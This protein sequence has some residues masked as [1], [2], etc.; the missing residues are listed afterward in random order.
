MA[1]TRSGVYLMCLASALYYSFFLLFCS[2]ESTLKSHFFSL[3]KNIR[4]NKY[5]VFK[6]L[7]IIKIRAFVANILFRVDSSYRKAVFVL[8]WNCFELI[9]FWRYSQMIS[10]LAE[11]C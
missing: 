11:N 5:H 10:F 3:K 8:L 1:A 4:E 7:Y 6:V 2:Y 9:H